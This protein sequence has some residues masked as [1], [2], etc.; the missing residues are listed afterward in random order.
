MATSFHYI[1]TT[2]EDGKSV[3]V[4]VSDARAFATEDMLA[5]CGFRWNRRE[6]TWIGTPSRLAGMQLLIDAGFIAANGSSCPAGVCLP[7]GDVVEYADA[8]RELRRAAVKRCGRT[9]DLF[10][11]ADAPEASGASVAASEA[12]CEPVEP[13]PVEYSVI[14]ASYARGKMVVRSLIR[15]GYKTRVDYLAEALG[16][17][18]VNRSGGYVMSP[19][20]AEKLARLHRAGFDAALRLFRDSPVYFYRN[21]GEKLSAREALKLAA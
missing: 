6:Q 8:V 17:R 5:A 1:A 21:H 13:Q 12:V 7:D 2:S 14:P 20:A 19:A 11:V 3:S 9:A 16:G 10:A 18:W 4:F 15:N